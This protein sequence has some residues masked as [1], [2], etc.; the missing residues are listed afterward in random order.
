MSEDGSKQLLPCGWWYPSILY[1]KISEGFEYSIL[2][3]TPPT[4]SGNCNVYTD[5]DR[6]TDDD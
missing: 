5:S 1:H 4:S 6:S 3:Y 2:E